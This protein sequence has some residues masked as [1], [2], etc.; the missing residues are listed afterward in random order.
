[1]TNKHRENLRKNKSKVCVKYLQQ[2]LA[3]EI[4]KILYMGALD[5]CSKHKVLFS[6]DNKGSKPSNEHLRR[7]KQHMITKYPT[8]KPPLPKYQK[9]AKSEEKK[10]PITCYF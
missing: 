5:T 7:V 3:C 2:K 10:P 4:D 9:G 6:H 1:M 8:M